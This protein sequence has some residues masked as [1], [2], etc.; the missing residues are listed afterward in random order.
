MRMGRYRI[1]GKPVPKIDGKPLVTGEGK[2]AAD[3]S[4]PG[5]LW[6]KI[7]R[8]P[9]PHARIVSMDTSKAE[10][11]PGVKAVVT[12]RET[13]GRPYGG[14]DGIAFSKDSY[15]LAVDKVRYVGDEVAAVAAVDDLTAEK[16]LDLIDVEYEELPYVLDPEEAM[17]ESAPLVHEEAGSNIVHTVNFVYGDVEEGFKKADHVRIDRFVTEPLNHCCL[18]PHAVLAYCERTGKLTVWTSTQ[19]M[20]RARNYLSETLGIPPSSIRIIK[21]YVGGA[22]GGKHGNVNPDF[23]AAFLSM[24]TGKPVKIVYTREEVFATTRGRH[25]L[26]ITLKTGFTKEGIITARDAVSITDAGAYSSDASH[27]VGRMGNHLTMLYRTPHVRFKGYLVYTNKPTGGAQRGYGGQQMRYADELQMDL[28]ARDLGID[29]LDLRLKNAV[30]SGDIT[31]HGYKIASCGFRE[32]LEKVARVSGYR[33]KKGKLPKGHGIAVASGGYICGL[34]VPIESSAYVRFDVDG[35]VVVLTGSSDVGQG[36]NSMLCQIVA[37]ELGVTFDR[38][39]IVVGDTDIT[40]PDGGTFSSRVTIMAGNAVLNAARDVKKQL[41]EAIS[42]QT[43]IAQEELG[44][45]DNYIVRRGTDQKLLSLN[46][47]ISKCPPL[48]GKGYYVNKDDVVMQDEATGAGNISPAYSFGA[49]V[50]EV[51]VDQRSGKIKVKQVTAAFDCGYAINPLAVVGQIEGSI[52]QGLGQA[53]SEIV[54]RD[55]RGRMLNP[56]F[57]TYKVPMIT[58]MP[59]INSIIV[60]TVDPEGPFGA[61]GVGEGMLLPVPPAVVNAVYDATNKLIQIPLGLE[62]VY[63]AISEKNS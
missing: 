18:E 10:K 15:G 11:L 7:L 52:S 45:I 16:A 38:I 42:K 25:P 32:C 41:L 26:V 14:C 46:E 5:M 22:F 60:E 57:L 53:I 12:G 39:R 51:E 30:E 9:V 63:R 34:R 56:S 35:S 8:S 19:N 33:E 21:P 37:E 43:S 24:K 28:I 27:M 1:V 36:S 17:S 13:L 47:A 58:E 40:P 48:L 55:N 20:M 4:L 49:E 50:A 62:K 23:C 44:L 3:I 29:P 31:P 6:G 59:K 2:F 54:L 61:K